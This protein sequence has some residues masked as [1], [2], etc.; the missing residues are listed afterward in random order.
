MN[1]P[2]DETT[3]NDLTA[4]AILGIDDT[5]IVEVDVPEWD[6][7]L[8][9]KTQTGKEYATMQSI[10]VNDPDPDAKKGEANRIG[11]MTALFVTSVCNAEG[12]LLFT[13]DHYQKIKVKSGAALKR[14]WD[15][16]SRI[17]GL[18]AQSRKA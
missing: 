9:V 6:G 17:N 3:K 18:D 15:V 5:E 1:D 8:F 14:V 2:T 16:S 11:L 4:E 10:L 13:P 7:R 12:E